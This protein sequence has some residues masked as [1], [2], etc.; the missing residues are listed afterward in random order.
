[1]RQK[2]EKEREVVRMERAVP[3]DRQ[4]PAHMEWMEEAEVSE[5]APA[6]VM[7]M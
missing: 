4:E 7:R 5:Q 2:R 1:M 3:L 6:F